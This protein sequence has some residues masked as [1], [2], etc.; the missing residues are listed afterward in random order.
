MNNGIEIVPADPRV[1]IRG[2]ACRAGGGKG[3]VDF[4]MEYRIAEMRLGGLAGGIT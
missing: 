1:L 4:S 3:T 2:A